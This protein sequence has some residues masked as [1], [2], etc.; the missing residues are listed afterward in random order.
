[1][2]TTTRTAIFPG[3]LSRLVRTPA[4]QSFLGSSV[5][6]TQVSIPITLLQVLAVGVSSTYLD[7]LKVDIPGFDIDLS[8]GSSIPI[9][10]LG[11]KE[12]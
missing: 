6:S 10:D 12:Y 3:H 1:M 9:L 8:H 11:F 2:S 5:L 7:H 4:P